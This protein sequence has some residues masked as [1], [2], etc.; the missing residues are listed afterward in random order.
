LFVFLLYSH[1]P[2]YNPEKIFKRRTRHY[3]T[4]FSA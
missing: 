4:I 2:F 1:F 3:I